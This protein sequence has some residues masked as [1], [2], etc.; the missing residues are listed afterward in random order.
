MPK[1]LGGSSEIDAEQ[2]KSLLNREFILVTLSGFIFFFNFH[3]FLLLPIRIKELGGSESDIGFIMGATGLS[4]IFTTPAV[5]MLV[6]RWGRK[7]FIALG[8]LFMS[9]TT[10]PFAYI[11][12]LNFLFPLLRIMHGAAFSLCFI[13]AG[14][15][16]ADVAPVSKRSQALGL[17]GVFT[18][19]NY[20]L[21]PFVGKRLIE[22][23]GFDVF[24]EVVF[25][26]GFLSFLIA[27]L[28]RESNKTTSG[29]AN[30]N[31]IL[32][33][34]FR[35]GVFV[36]A[37]TLM[38]SGSGFIP[39]L[40]FIPVF[41]EH[42]KVESFDLF[43]IA[44]TLSTLFVRI[45]GGWIPDRLGKKRAAIPSL[46]FFALSIMGISFASNA[47]HFIEAGI[48]F[49]LS[50]GLVYP[51]IYALVIDLSPNVDR[52]KAFAIC[53]VSFTLGGMLGSFIYGV[54]AEH[55]GFHV[56]YMAAG[57]VCLIGFLV[58]SL[59]GKDKVF[60]NGKI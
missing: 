18:I 38:I 11:H 14:T 23:F 29:A 1:Y 30:G 35:K 46:F 42:I 57:V 53:S 25:I 55:L 45:F 31:G 6:D 33:T 5:G 28:I 26:F 13:S 52:G 54:V 48:L 19:V 41:A 37:F 8:G 27:L 10:L 60:E 40:T 49:G 12:T 58:F 24:F 9:L 50:H 20:A 2:Q 59:F 17:F 47:T 39:T 36:A 3:A 4:T 16:T 43:F 56:M 34:L 51:S 7:W 32:T 44:Y 22:A 15:L 21:A